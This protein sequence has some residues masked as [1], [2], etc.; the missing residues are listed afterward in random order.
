M[1]AGI[2]TSN[3]FVP[4]SDKPIFKCEK[5]EKKRAFVQPTVCP[6]EIL[7]LNGLPKKEALLEKS[8][9]PKRKK[10]K[11]KSI[12]KNKNFLNHNLK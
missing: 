6:L 8:K 10:N 9:I 11:R 12:R 2:Q 3:S 5:V 4:P 7:S 1:G